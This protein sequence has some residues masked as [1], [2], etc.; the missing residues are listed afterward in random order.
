MDFQLV[1]IDGGAI[2]TH[3]GINSDFEKA[4]SPVLL[5]FWQVFGIL[6]EHLPNI[7]HLVYRNYYPA[8]WHRGNF[9]RD[10]LRL[11]NI[12]ARRLW[13]TLPSAKPMALFRQK[14]GCRF[15]RVRYGKIPCQCLK[16]RYN[17]HSSM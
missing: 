15:F 3:T 7:L 11:Q 10:H 2:S 8:T 17:A 9:F 14:E 12:K 5:S 13:L 6:V 16:I 4:R 1:K